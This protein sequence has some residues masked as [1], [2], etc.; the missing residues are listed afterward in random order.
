[1]LRKVCVVERLLVVLKFATALVLD[2]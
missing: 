2:S 1:L